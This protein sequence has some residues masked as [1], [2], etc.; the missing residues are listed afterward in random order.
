M[1]LSL[2]PISST[3]HPR[4]LLKRFHIQEAMLSNG[5]SLDFQKSIKFQD[6]AWTA[7]PSLAAFMK[8]GRARMINAFKRRVGIVR[9]PTRLSFAEGVGRNVCV[10]GIMK[11]LFFDHGCSGCSRCSRTC[12]SRVFRDGYAIHLGSFLINCYKQSNLDLS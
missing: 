3:F 1:R 7:R 4:F 6:F 2:I 12:Q 10:D 5:T 8:D 9:F 11:I